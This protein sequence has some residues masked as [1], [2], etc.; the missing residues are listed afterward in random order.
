MMPSSRVKV[1]A[2]K[3]RSDNSENTAYTIIFSP[4]Q[5]TIR[6]ARSIRKDSSC[7]SWAWIEGGHSPRGASPHQY[8]RSGDDLGP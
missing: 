5:V 4:H 7:F 8:Y 6:F 3:P 1:T 2:V